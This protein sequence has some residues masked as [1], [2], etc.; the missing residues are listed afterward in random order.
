MQ[1]GRLQDIY[2]DRP[3]GGSGYPYQYDRGN[4]VKQ[5]WVQQVGTEGRPTNRD[6]PREPLE[7]AQ[8]AEGA[9][10]QENSRSDEMLNE[11]L[12]ETARKILLKAKH[13]DI[14]EIIQKDI[15]F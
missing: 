1:E 3:E 9:R 6:N 15:K 11:A 12:K 7:N 2:D 14:L 5:E 8:G 10:N 13:D 4:R